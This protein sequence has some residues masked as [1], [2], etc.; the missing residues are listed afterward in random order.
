VIVVTQGGGLRVCAGEGSRP[1]R[2][3]G[4]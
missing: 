2:T 4:V 1:G 3:S